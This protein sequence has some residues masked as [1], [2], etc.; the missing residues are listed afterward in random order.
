VSEPTF[1]IEDEDNIP[2]ELL[3]A[4]TNGDRIQIDS[5][6]GWIDIEDPEF[7]TLNTYRILL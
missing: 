7:R 4:T 6:I 1:T 5:A 2:R 3:D